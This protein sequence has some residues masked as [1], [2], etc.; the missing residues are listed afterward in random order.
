M[1]GMNVGGWLRSAFGGR[2]KGTQNGGARVGMQVLANEGT[3][4]GTIATVWRGADATDGAP[5]DDTYG[6]KKPDAADTSMLFIPSSAVAKVSDKDVTLTVDEH[7]IGPRGWR[8]R[9]AWLRADEGQPE[10]RA[11]WGN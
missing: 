8:F 4:L 11:G 6:V 2:G 9:P 3:V 1:A 5:H 10:G 7:Q